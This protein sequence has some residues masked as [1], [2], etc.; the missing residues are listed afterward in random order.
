VH[1]GNKRRGPYWPNAYNPYQIPPDPFAPGGP[2]I[3]KILKKPTV[4]PAQTP[5]TL[6][7]TQ[8]GLFKTIDAVFKALNATNPNITQDFWLCLNPEPPYYVGLG[9]DAT[10]GFRKQ[11]VQNWTQTEITKN[12]SVCL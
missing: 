4:P 11:D 12:K 10:L 9:V 3:K 2:K 1:G 7:P 6:R 8:R 5:P